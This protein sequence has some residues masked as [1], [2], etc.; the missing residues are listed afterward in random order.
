M[1]SLDG[2]DARRP[3]QERGQDAPKRIPLIA[4]NWKMYKSIA[5]AEEFIQAL[6]PKVSTAD[7]GHAIGSSS[8]WPSILRGYV[9]LRR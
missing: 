6:L 2:P 7:G 5:E 1:T 8:S 4:G 9:W 3:N